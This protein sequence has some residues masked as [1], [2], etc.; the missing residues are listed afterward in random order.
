MPC[1]SGRGRS[2]RWGS[3][4]SPSDDILLIHGRI[5]GITPQQALDH[6][7][8]RGGLESAAARP[9]NYAAYLGADLAHQGT[10][11]AHGIAESQAFVDGN[12]RTAA[13]ALDAFLQ[14]NGHR[15]NVDDPVLAAWMLDLSAGLSAEELAD[16]IRPCLTPVDDEGLGTR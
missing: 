16:R 2:T 3:P 8:N 4:T 15:L 6:L 11:L 10:A 13:I 12:K 5:F 7:R 9:R 14:L 1:P